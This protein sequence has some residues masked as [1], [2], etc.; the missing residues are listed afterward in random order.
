MNASEIQRWLI[1]GLLAL[2]TS[3]LLA[4][5]TFAHH[6]V[7]SLGVAGLEGPGAPVETST[8]A[9]LP[10]GSW[11]AYAK[12]DYADFD[13]KTPERD[14]EGDYNAFWTFGLGFGFTPWLSGYLFV[15]YYKKTVEDGSADASGLADISLT[16]VL[17]FKY[18]EGLRLVPEAESLD[19]LED[20]HFTLYGG[21]TLPTGDANVRTRSDEIDPGQSLGFGR[22]SYQ[23]GLT[24][25]KQL[26]ERNTL[27]FDTS[28]IWFDEYK[29]DD[30]NKTQFGAEFRINLALTHRVYTSLKSR[31]RV[32][33]I[34]E[35][36]YLHLARDETN[37]V[38]ED[39]TGGHILYLQP[40]L[41]LYKNN[42]SAGVGIKFPSWKGLNEED[43]QQ[44]AEGT[45]DYR[46]NL[47]ISVLFQ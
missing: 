15:P 7:A 40:G 35:A 33:L 3:S 42:V 19:D 36:N 25:T 18:D 29:Y 27:V 23:V 43:E 47:T 44:G 13:K 17:G 12:L 32:D 2:S 1:Q 41:R 10:K 31:F 14:D 45:E 24:G 8:S 20:W 11:L 21:L 9:T 39:G 34:M 46:L 16:G 28:Y 4:S 26:F 5:P 30:G 38:E 6:G 37:G 22:P